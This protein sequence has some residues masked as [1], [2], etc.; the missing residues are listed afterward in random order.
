MH[1]ISVR[2]ASFRHLQST[3]RN[4]YGALSW[5]LNFL[6][7]DFEPDV[8]FLRPHAR[9]LGQRLQQFILLLTFEAPKKNRN[10]GCR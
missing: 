3:Y 2:L 8:G 9:V 6:L 4:S 1:R 7:A 5:H 10:G